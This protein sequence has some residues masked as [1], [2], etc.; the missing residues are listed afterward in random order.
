MDVSEKAAEAEPY[1][2]R[3]RLPKEVRAKGSDEAEGETPQSPPAAEDPPREG[4]GVPSDP[5]DGGKTPGKTGRKAFYGAL[6]GGTLA[7]LAIAA[8]AS[9]GAQQEI[10]RAGMEAASAAGEAVY[11]EE[12]PSPASEEDVPARPDE[13]GVSRDEGS[14]ENGSSASA[15]HEHEWS[16]VKETVHHDAETATVHH[17]ARYEQ[18]VER[19]TVCNVCRAQIDGAVREHAA[20][21]GHTGHTT[22]V[23]VTANR[24]VAEA[25]DEEVVVKEAYDEEKTVGRECKAC[26]AV[27]AYDAKE[28]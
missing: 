22:G 9:A 26:G 25:Y 3:P 20:A 23:P 6:F 14:S 11:L 21:T 28:E 17:E 8:F 10:A 18:V 16:D 1:R 19:H 13:P 15:G 4:E 24:L 27:E 2:I 5:S 7:L 12:A